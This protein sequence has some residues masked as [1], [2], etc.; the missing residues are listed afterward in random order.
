M[1][2]PSPIIDWE[3]LT[4]RLRS[5]PNFGVELTDRISADLAQAKTKGLEQYSRYLHNLSGIGTFAVRGTVHIPKYT[6]AFGDWL[7]LY[8][9]GDPEIVGEEEN[10]TD[11]EWPY[12]TGKVAYSIRGSYFR[13]GKVVVEAEKAVEDGAPRILYP[14]GLERFDLLRVSNV[15][16]LEHRDQKYIA[17]VL[18]FLS[19]E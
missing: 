19:A 12:H 15:D 9:G 8:D 1:A 5:D 4:E 17:G 18:R 14:D 7:I 11:D 2:E 13:D 3:A 10:D 16:I 6:R